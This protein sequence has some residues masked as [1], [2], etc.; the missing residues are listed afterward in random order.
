MKNNA[1]ILCTVKI[2]SLSLKGEGEACLDENFLPV[3]Y[4][5]P[6]ETVEVELFRDRNKNTR[7]KVRRWLE[8]SDKRNNPSCPHFTECGGCSLQH[9]L[10]QDYLHFK[11]RQIAELLERARVPVALLE[12]PVILG[13]HKR[14]RIDFKACLRDEGLVMGFHQKHSKRR[15]D[16]QQCPVVRPEIEALF[17]PLR[18]LLEQILNPR[19]TIHI[20]IA[21]AE[22]GVDLLLTGLKRPF[23]ENHKE[24]MIRFAE[25]NALARLTLQVK[26]TKETLFFREQPYVVFSKEK[27]SIHPQVF[28]QASREA[29]QILA[30]KIIE[31]IPQKTKKIADLFCGRGTLSIPLTKAG[32]K[33]D[34]FEADLHAIEALNGAAIPDLKGHVRDLFAS[35][36][37]SEELDLY[38]CAVADPPRTGLKDQAVAIVRSSLKTFIYV[39]CGPE[40]FSQDAKYLTD[41]G[42][43]LERLIP[44]D[45][46]MWSSH[47]EIISLFTRD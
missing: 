13:P 29:D 14:R 16:L 25:E 43:K 33:V 34:G 38:D 32:I 35:P 40:S 1:P 18:S 42:F 26:R 24:L 19:E 30:E 17:S 21:A 9:L 31:L 15:V 27:I 41:Q 4:A 7:G 12:D 6:G 5:L 45:Q 28:L 36:L 2:Q 46:F 8:C 10:P 37:S 47:L 3:P 20:F 44:L 23:E 11:K 22:N 39:S